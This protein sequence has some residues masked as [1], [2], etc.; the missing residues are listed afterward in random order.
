MTGFFSGE[1]AFKHGFQGQ[2]GK[3]RAMGRDVQAPFS[4]KAGLKKSPSIA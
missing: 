1:T 2:K 3:K 4:A